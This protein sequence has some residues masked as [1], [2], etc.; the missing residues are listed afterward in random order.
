MYSIT[1]KR[2]QV[3]FKL[4]PLCLAYSQMV[5]TILLGNKFAKTNILSSLVNGF[6]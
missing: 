1:N 3:S 4:K 2:S 6:H 5:E